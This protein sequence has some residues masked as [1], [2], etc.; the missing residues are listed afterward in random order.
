FALLPVALF[1]H[2]AH[3]LMHLLMEGGALVP[4]LSD[5]MGD[6]SNYLGTA[7]IHIGHLLP[8]SVVW[9]LQLGLI[10]IGHLF[11]V[12]VAHRISRRLFADRRHALRSLLPMT[13]VMVAVSVAGLTL[14]ALDMSMKLGRS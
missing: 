1:Y 13:T 4:L 6:G 2:L 7:G 11:G 10:L 14:M 8:E 5:P 9:Y 12:V 3:N